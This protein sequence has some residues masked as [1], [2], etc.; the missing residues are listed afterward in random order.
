MC[1]C[2]HEY[3][4]EGDPTHE[5]EKKEKTMGDVASGGSTKEESPLDEPSAETS[6]EAARDQRRREAA[7]AV[8]E[9]SRQLDV[10]GT[11]LKKAKAAYRLATENYKF[12]YKGVKAGKSAEEQDAGQRVRALMVKLREQYQTLLREHLMQADDVDDLDELVGRIERVHNPKRKSMPGDDDL[13]HHTDDPKELHLQPGLEKLRREGRYIFLRPQEEGVSVEGPEVYVPQA[14][15]EEIE[16]KPLYHMDAQVM[17][18]SAGAQQVAYTA[19]TADLMFDAGGGKKR[20]EKVI[21]DS[22]AAC[23]A[24][25]LDK[26]RRDYGE[27]ARTMRAPTNTLGFHDASGGL[28][29]VAGYVDMTICI[30]AHCFSTTVTVFQKLH[31]NF[32]LGT[33]TLGKEGIIIDAS[34]QT[35]YAKKHCGETACLCM[36]KTSR[37]RTEYSSRDE[38]LSFVGEDGTRD[39]FPC[40]CDETG[41]TGTEGTTVATTWRTRVVCAHDVKIPK[42]AKNVHVKCKFEEHYEGSD[43]ELTI[44]VSPNLKR[45][46]PKLTTFRSQRHLSMNYHVQVAVSNGGCATVIKAGAEIGTAVV[47]AKSRELDIVPG[48]SNKILAVELMDDED[49]PFEEGGRPRN[50]ED[51]KALGFDLDLCVNPGK[52]LEGGGYAPLE[53]KYKEKLYE[54]ALRWHRAWSRDARVPRLSRLVVIDIPTGEAAPIQQKPYGIPRK[55]LDAV[56]EEMNKLLKAGLIEPS[57][58]NWASPTL[59]T[60]K[61]DSTTDKL[62]IKIVVD[63]RRLNEVTIPD[64]GGLGNQQEI[65]D[66][67]GGGKIFA[68]ICDAAGGFYQYVLNPRHREKSTFILP[69]SMGGTAF[70]WRVAPYGLQRNPASY[71]RGMMFA[72]QNLVDIP[73]MPMGQSTGSAYSWVDDITMSSDT[74]EGFIDLFERVL[75]RVTFSG[76]T[77]KGEKCHILRAELEVLG[78]HVT[79]EGLKMQPSKIESILRMKVPSNVDEIRTYLGSVGFYRRFI[80]RLGVLAT[81][82]HGALKKGAKLDHKEIAASFAAVNEYLVSD[83]VIK[84][85]DFKDPLAHFVICPD[86]SNVAAG[87]VLMQ[88]QHPTHAGAGPTEAETKVDKSKDELVD[89]WR[90]EKG[91][92]LET[93]GFF[94]KTFVQA[95]RNWPTFD[96]EAGAIILALRH[97]TDI[98]TSCVTTVYTDSSVAAS[99]LSNKHSGP[100]RLQRWGM[101]LMSFLPYLRIAYRRGIDNG[102]ADL[103]SRFPLFEKYV[104][105]N[106]DTAE[107]PEDLFEKIGEA[108][109][110]A[111]ATQA[112]R[113]TGYKLYECRR[114]QKLKEIWQSQDEYQ[115]LTARQLLQRAKVEHEEV[116]GLNALQDLSPYPNPSTLIR[117]AKEPDGLICHIQLLKMAVERSPFHEE[118]RR[119]EEAQDYWQQYV[120]AFEATN[121]RAPVLYD[122]YCGDGCYS[123]GARLAGV[124]CYGFDIRMEHAKRYERDNHVEGKPASGMTFTKLD[125][126]RP[127]FWEQ[128]I[129]RGRYEHL[130]MPDLI[131]GSP[132]CE[133]F[134]RLT[135]I[136]RPDEQTLKKVDQGR[137]RLQKL[138]EKLR[139]YQRAM[140]AQKNQEIV[141]QV[142]NVPESLAHLP[143]DLVESVNTVK[144]CGTMFGH[145]VFKH[146]IFYCS[147]PATIGLPHDHVGKLLGSRGISYVPVK[148]AAALEPNM[149]GVYS[150]SSH[151]RGTVAIWNGALGHPPETASIR[152][153]AGCLP[154]GYGRYLTAQMVAHHLRQQWDMPVVPPVEAG[155]VHKHRL[156]QWAVGGYVPA[157]PV[158]LVTGAICATTATALKPWPEG[159]RVE[160]LWKGVGTCPATWWVGTVKAAVV[161]YEDQAD[162]SQRMWRGIEVHYDL[163]GQTKIHDLATSKVR[164]RRC[165]A[166]IPVE[167]LTSQERTRIAIRVCNRAEG[168]EDESTEDDTSEESS[169]E[170]ESDDEDV[171]TPCNPEPYSVTIEEQLRDPWCHALI[172]DLRG[173]L[174]KGPGTAEEPPPQTIVGNAVWTIQ[175]NLLL[176]VTVGNDHEAKY[177]TAVPTHLRTELMAHEHYRG[178][179]SADFLFKGL[180]NQY[181]WATMEADCE[182]FKLACP[183]CGAMLTRKICP[184]PRRDHQHHH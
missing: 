38:L 50:R 14:K 120:S 64:S 46:H 8:E 104:S 48:D 94:S 129:S 118:Q 32:L 134:S 63:Y 35:M 17:A 49:L 44:T 83:A 99:M 42:G 138:M 91:W 133:A 15:S 121:G 90:H 3:E 102:M 54:I 167:D 115:P 55:Y 1:G 9:A 125:L 155:S 151:E 146:R 41:F 168:I 149:Y 183:V 124:E 53:D 77:L 25:G 152:G 164:R 67:F 122:L 128:M 117:H 24:I 150:R 70:Q 19:M 147:Y 106:D 2:E 76:I 105:R 88:W 130:P 166:D 95:Q 43:T 157:M 143:G 61:K 109:Y 163:D 65:L 170:S 107:M 37:I 51:L 172:R 33:N 87:A 178:H 154:Q 4:S 47:S 60:V 82:M 78:F 20:S 5:H 16:S 174:P 40:K 176:R 79:P 100:P 12:N 6:N 57:I 181:Y 69:T 165:L 112:K 58:S 126:D 80:P 140:K 148:N 93:L 30:G 62:K 71:S 96:K 92:K 142:E 28:M 81:P 119:Y 145:R 137:S 68:A 173:R 114:P 116:G 108:P 175:E 144:L 132:P 72:L 113:G 111:S 75:M 31:C 52:P 86:A 13:S 135:S 110:V 27:L 158:S 162:G 171:C 159:S 84:P 184:S 103:L 85:P 97:W 39:S 36:G 22:G 23:S 177:Q 34:D 160:V 11:K 141:W 180:S 123:R 21:V 59:L 101:E 10:L 29:P 127:E 7:R 89:S 74:M 18:H 56:R 161:E 182:K 45:D 156:A 136:N 169:E 26:L 98:V 73:L 131:H 139:E 66:S 179:R 153:I